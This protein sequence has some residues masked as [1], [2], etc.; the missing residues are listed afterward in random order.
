MERHMKVRLQGLHTARPVVEAGAP[1]SPGHAWW[2]SRRVWLVAALF[3]ALILISLIQMLSALD[4]D[5]G[6]F[7]VIA[8]EIPHGR[9]PYRDLFDNKG[10]G[11]YF[12]L[13]PV[14]MLTRSADLMMQIL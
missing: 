1:P 5:E 6:T 12:L 9:L 4:P 13:A 11:I 14:L 8:R 10:P 2:R 7:L 3:A